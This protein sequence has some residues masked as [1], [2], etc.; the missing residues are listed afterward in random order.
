MLALCARHGCGI[1]FR[2]LGKPMVAMAFSM[3]WVMSTDEFG[4]RTSNFIVYMGA[5]KSLDLS[6]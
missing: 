3:P 5:T 2:T 6:M 4:L 1:H